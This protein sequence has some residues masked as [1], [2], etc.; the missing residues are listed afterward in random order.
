MV[1][2]KKITKEIDALESG[3]KKFYG[4]DFTVDEFEVIFKFLLELQD[5]GII[6]IKPHHE[7]T[8]GHKLIDAA[9]V[10]KL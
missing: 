6:R 1:D 2:I 4:N 5:R 9:F 8:S 10:E 3:Q 7:S